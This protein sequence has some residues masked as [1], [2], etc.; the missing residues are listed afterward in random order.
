MAFR[1]RELHIAPHTTTK[2]AADYT[3][4]EEFPYSHEPQ[5]CGIDEQP[6]VAKLSGSGFLSVQ[7][8]QEPDGS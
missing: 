3:H 7:T 8:N 4:Y 1:T 5:L 6:P 2:T